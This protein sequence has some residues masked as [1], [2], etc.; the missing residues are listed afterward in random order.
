MFAILLPRALVLYLIYLDQGMSLW[1]V[2]HL[3][4]ALLVWA[5]G[6]HTYRRRAGNARG[7]ARASKANIWVSTPAYV[8][9][10]SNIRDVGEQAALFLKDYGT[11]TGRHSWRY[12]HG[13]S[14]IY[15]TS[16]QSPLV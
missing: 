9:R 6:G 7:R 10:F 8:D 15:S 16:A 11:A 14:A 5:G 4:V 1:F 2:I 13:R 12:R 3:V